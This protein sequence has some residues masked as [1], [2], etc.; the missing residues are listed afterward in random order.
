M[1]GLDPVQSQARQL[2]EEHVR[3]HL[4]SSLVIAQGYL[5]DRCKNRLREAQLNL[6]DWF[7]HITSRIKWS[8]WLKLF[9]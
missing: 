1:M 9:I 7:T 2:R 8:Q 3:R 6:L 4:W 5:N